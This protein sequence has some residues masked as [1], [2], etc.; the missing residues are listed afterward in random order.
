MTNRGGLA[1]VTG[2][3]LVPSQFN[4]KSEMIYSSQI[5]QFKASFNNITV[6]GYIYY[7]LKWSRNDNSQCVLY[8]NPNGLIISN[9][10]TPLG[11]LLHTP[12]NIELLRRCPIIFYDYR[13]T[14][15]NKNNTNKR[16]QDSC[17]L[18]NLSF[19]PTYESIVIDGLT[20]LTKI[21]NDFEYVES[22]GSSL[23]G[24]VAV[25]SLDRYLNKFPNDL[26]RISLVNHD[27]F[28]KTTRVIC[29]YW[30]LI[31]DTLGWLIGGQLDAETP[32]KN[33]IIK[34]VKIKILSHA[35]DH[36]IPTGAHLFESLGD[37]LKRDNVNFFLSP[38][39]GHADIT[40]DMFT[41][42]KNLK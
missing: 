2:R 27:S 33:L 6:N 36:V 3:F 5:V 24:G 13:G 7:P 14:G 10:V 9:Y 21:I 17:L 29:P 32:T 37:L 18:S 19:R 15:I 40:Q 28:S 11:K 22:W 12:R 31:P 16:D 8:H 1:Q 20:I 34:N 30:T 42:M 35:K 38:L 23:G 39:E 4:D 25:A 41:Y 26:N